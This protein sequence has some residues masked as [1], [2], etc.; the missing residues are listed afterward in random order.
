MEQGLLRTPLCFPGRDVFMRKLFVLLC[1]SVS[2]LFLVS[3][4]ENKEDNAVEIG[5]K[6]IKELYN[7]GNSSVDLNKMNAEQ[8][9][10]KQSEFSI[11]FTEEEF[12]DLANKR[13]FLIP[14]EVGSKQNNT[15]SVQ[16]I[17]FEKYEQGQSESES[18]DFNHSFTLIFTDPEG[19][20]ADK[21]KMKGQMTIVNTENGLKIDRYYDGET[22]KDILNR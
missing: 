1:C 18:L 15:I 6:F 17:K 5:E 14:Q 22:L 10:D 7:V 16:N 19:N 11:Y 4:C 12:E 2:L 20:E 21:A 8:L 3:A 9:I 13:F